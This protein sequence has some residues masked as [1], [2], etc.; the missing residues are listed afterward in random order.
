MFDIYF[1]ADLVIFRVAD[2]ALYVI[3]NL[4]VPGKRDQ[5]ECG[6]F[7]EFYICMSIYTEKYIKYLISRKK[8]TKN[9]SARPIFF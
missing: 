9:L 1:L 2:I 3:K 7:N 6:V 5:Q 4:F 8:K